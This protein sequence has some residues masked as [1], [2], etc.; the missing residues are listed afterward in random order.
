MAK[1]PKMEVQIGKPI[2]RLYSSDRKANSKAIQFKIGEKTSI[3]SKGE[4][5]FNP[6]IEK[7]ARRLRKETKERRVRAK[8]DI[9]LTVGERSIFEEI[10][11]EMATNNRSIKELNAPN[12][13][14]QPLC[15]TYSNT[16]DVES[17][18]LP[19]LV[20]GQGERLALLSSFGSIETW[21]DMKQQFLQRFFPASRATHLRKEIYGIRQLNGESLYEYWER[22]KELV[23]SYP[24]HQFTE[25]LLIQYFYEGLSGMDRRM[26]DAASGGA[27]IDKTP[28]EAQHLISTIAENYRLYG[29]H[30]DKGAPKVN[31]VRQTQETIVCGICSNIGHP[32]DACPLLQEG[33]MPN[34][35]AVGG[36]FGQP[37]R[38]YDPNSNFYNPGW[39]DHPNF[40]YRNQGEQSKPHQQPI[41]RVVPAPG[42]TLS[43]PPNS[44]MSLE[45]IVKSLALTTQQIQQDT[46]RVFNTW[47]TKSL[48]SPHLLASWRLKHLESYPLKQKQIEGEC[49][50]NNTSSGKELQ[51]TRPTPRKA[52][53]E[54]NALD[55]TD[56]THDEVESNLIPPPLSN[57]CALSFPYRMSKSK[58][59]EHEKEILD[60]FK[61][62]EINIPL[63]DAIKQIPKYAKFLKELCT[64]KR[65]LKDKER[66][67]FGK[68]VS[69]VINRK[70]PEKCKDPGMFTLPCII[71]NKRIERAM[72]DLGAS[73]NVMPYSVYQA[74]NLSTLQDTNVIIQLADRSY[75]R[76][77]GL[78]EDVL[79]KVNDLLFPVDFYI[80]KMGVEGVNNPASILLGRPFMKTAKTKIDVDEGTLS[81]EFGGEIVKFNISEAM[82]YPNELQALYQIDVIDSVVHDVVE[83][84]LVG[85]EL[86][87]IMELDEN[88]VEDDFVETLSEALRPPSLDE[89]NYST[90]HTKLLPSVLQAPK[91]EL[92]PL[93]EHLKYIY[94]GNE[95]TLPAIISSK[96]SKEHEEKLVTLLREHRTAIGWTLADIKGISP[97]MLHGLARHVVPKKTGMTVVKNQ[98][99]ELVTIKLPLL[100]KT[101][102]R[103][104]TCPFGTFAFRRMPFGLCNAPDQGIVLGHVI[105]SRGIEVDKAKVDLIVNLPYPTSVREIRSFLGHAGFYRRFIKDFAKIA[106]PLSQ[107]LQKDANFVFGGDCQEAFDELKRALTSAPIIQPPDWST[108]FEIMCD[109]SNYAVGAVL[110]QKIEK[111]HHVIYYALKN[112]GCSTVQ[113]LDY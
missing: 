105:S 87:L 45:D 103:Q 33:V 37:Q 43:K 21:A 90:T 18:S 16:N 93:P 24:H 80:L 73:I 57:T 49:E 70:L 82:K 67:I 86:D 74:L 69:A 42:Q 46:T 50:C 104:L 109:A 59:E 10:E 76:P 101:K 112:F 32:T 3:V 19:L 72:L 98:N 89:S 64:N 53:I 61:K 31:E 22:F 106:Q 23:A 47:A 25:S 110:G 36:F 107:L 12:S 111:T 51:P 28:D 83:E 78:V 38:R 34:V 68:N 79:V 52:G 30:T 9:D 7:T 20:E 6:E 102:K 15:I 55:D 54:K 58:E 44:G 1:R 13:D 81:V 75:V 71:G 96:L 66:I 8:L 29:Y 84:E 99:G 91:L 63:L 4:L 5:Q 14:Q 56:A 40:S 39:R 27:L 92:K 97:A 65:K 60:T 62:V 88:D 41:N 11:P 100:K 94:L 77:M 48:N 2:P 35:N 26:V 108:P 85:T 113:L 17:E 95:E